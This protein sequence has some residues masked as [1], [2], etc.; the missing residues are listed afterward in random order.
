MAINTLGFNV[1]GEYAPI[2]GTTP[3]STKIF[4]VLASNSHLSPFLLTFETFDVDSIAETAIVSIGTNSPDY[5]NILAAYP[6][7][8][9]ALTVESHALKSAPIF[10]N[11]TDIYTRVVRAANGTTLTF[12]VGVGY[13]AYDNS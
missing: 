5:D 3:G 9:N 6:I 2:D 13:L 7:N 8:T 11:E 1:S 10:V 12:V 4:Q